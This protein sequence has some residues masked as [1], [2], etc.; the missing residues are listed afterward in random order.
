VQH[1][2]GLPYL[3]AIDSLRFGRACIEYLSHCDILYETYSV[4]SFGGAWAA[5]RLSTPLV[6][7]VHADVINVEQPLLGKRLR[8]IQ[9]WLAE[10]VTRQCLARATRIVA[11]SEVVADRLRTHWGIPADRV[12]TVPCGV[13]PKLFAFTEESQETRSR[14]SLGTDPIVMFVGFF[15]PWHGIHDLVEAFSRVVLEIPQAKLVLVGDG[16]VRADIEAHVADAGLSDKVV[17]TGRVPH[18][19]VPALLSIAN[20]AVVPYPNL[21]S[22]IWFSP[23]KLYEY[24]AAGKAIVASSAGQIAEVVED[25]YSGLLV[26]PGDVQ[27]LSEAIVRLLK[28]TELRLKLGMHARKEAVEKH[29]YTSRARELEAIFSSVLAM[30]QRSL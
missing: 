28:N 21:P 7:E 4:M 20:V 8:G 26:E 6:L 23:L 29:S 30:R 9:F 16:P 1:K 2:L 15:F 17:L 10:F 24:M 22:E 27:A 18:E 11:I 13:D 25:G 5:S 12:V 3:G 19:R 14:F